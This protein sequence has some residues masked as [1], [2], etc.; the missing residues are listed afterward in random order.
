MV[1]QTRAGT[2]PHRRARQERR[3]PSY[4][5]AVPRRR[6]GDCGRATCDPVLLADKR[7]P[8]MRSRRG[9]LASPPP[10]RTARA[11]ELLFVP[12]K[13][14]NKKELHSRALLYRG[15]R[16]HPT[17]SVAGPRATGRGAC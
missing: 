14:G 12:E 1:A 4:S 15:V 3:S 8:R 9:R 6:R 13:N 10:G 17:I 5:I 16:K 11:S 7:G 2:L